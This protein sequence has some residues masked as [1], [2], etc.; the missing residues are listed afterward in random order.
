MGY[1][2]SGNA[3]VDAMGSFSITGNIIADEWYKIIRKPKT[4]KPYLLA[5]DILAD[6]VYWMRPTEIRDERTGEVIGWKKK[7]HGEMLQ[8]SYQEYANKYCE[9][10]KTIKLAFDQL[11]AIGVIRRYFYNIEYE[12]GR[13]IPNQM[14]I[15][16]NMK[17][18]EEISYPKEEGGTTAKPLKRK[19][20]PSHCADID[21]NT[22]ETRDLSDMEDLDGI[23][24]QNDEDMLTNLSGY[25]EKSVPISSPEN[26]AYVDRSEMGSCNYGKGYPTGT[27]RTNTKNNTKNNNK[28]HITSITQESAMGQM[29]EKEVDEIR[30]DAEFMDSIIK[31]HI[32]YD[33]H[34]ENDDVDR[35]D[36]FHEL[37]LLMH[38]VMCGKHSGA[39]M[40]NR[41]PMDP[42]AVRKRYLRLNDQHLAYV[43]DSLNNNPNSD[44]IGDIRS[45]M[46]TCLYNA[47]VTMG[48]YYKQRFNHDETNCVYQKMLQEKKRSGDYDFMEDDK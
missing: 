14:F 12:D 11:V 17:V 7:F 1:R 6:I 20:I 4:G 38:D 25:P 28:D 42:D 23:S 21:E 19:L 44:G 35:A 31:R 5:I 22:D 13:I 34:M 3:T 26:S 8:K 32:N 41:T 36:D 45:Y 39:I 27:I 43:I 10:K 47:P 46:M 15:D 33:W 18:L 29:R 30:C 2:S 37:Y 48:Q 16:I 9:S 40:I 24:L